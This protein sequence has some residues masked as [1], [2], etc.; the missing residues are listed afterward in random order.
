MAKKRNDLDD[1]LAVMP[2]PQGEWAYTDRMLVALQA[3][4]V[5]HAGQ[6]RKGSGVPYLTHLLGTCSIALEY[7]ASE[8]E[9]I[10]ALLHDVIED[11]G[12]T[13]Q[14]RKAVRW[15]GREV[16]DIVLACTDGVPDKHGVKPPWEGRKQAY[17]DHLAGASRSALLVSA[18]DKLHNAR[19]I[20]ADQRAIGDTVFTRFRK[21]KADTLAYYQ[22]LVLAF[23]KNPA[24]HPAL[25]DEL[26]RT[27][28][29]MVLLA[30][31]S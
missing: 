27:V 28:Q 15:F 9:A 13:K 2:L 10:A 19:S 6:R 29:T 5:M 14:A 11:V 12:P 24:H 8:N 25:I 31:Q 1:L 4:A 17:I 16:Y 22:Q 20:V 30:G 3:A 21:G 26:D 23:R 18:S 7:G